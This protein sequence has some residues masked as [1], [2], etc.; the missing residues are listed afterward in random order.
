MMLD[1]SKWNLTLWSNKIYCR[2]GNLLKFNFD[3]KIKLKSKIAAL[4]K[5]VHW[6]TVSFKG[7]CQKGWK[8]KDLRTLRL[9]RSV[10]TFLFLVLLIESCLVYFVGLRQGSLQSANM[11][12]KLLPKKQKSRKRSGTT[13]NNCRIS[14]FWSKVTWKNAGNF[15]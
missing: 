11:H 15:V 6:P 10:R 7:K 12:E 5:I 14:S 2:V 3:C 4:W 8:K 1:V 13:S 9:K